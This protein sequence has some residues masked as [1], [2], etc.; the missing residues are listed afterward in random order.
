MNKPASTLS[1]NTL[2]IKVTPMTV[3]LLKTTTQQR[4]RQWLA[5][6]MTVITCSVHASNDQEKEMLTRLV[7]ELQVLET[8]ISASEASA[9]TGD[10]QPFDYGALRRDIALMTQGVKDHLLMTRRDP[11]ALPPLAGEYRQ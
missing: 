6:I 4:C 9:T 11:R 10:R 1:D 7:T 2:S 3:M 5:L 8:L